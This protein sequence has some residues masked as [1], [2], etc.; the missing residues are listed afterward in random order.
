MPKQ[1]ADL[2]SRVSASKP[3]PKDDAYH[4][5]WVENLIQHALEKLVD[6]DR[7]YRTVQMFYF[8]AKTQREIAEA[9]DRKE[10]DVENDLAAA[11]RRLRKWIAQQI[12]EYCS[13][14]EEYESEVQDLQKFL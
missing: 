10:K 11:R 8:Q 14:R 9:L 4:R 7:Q 3:D 1:D 6:D 2:Y 13:S 12:A 5:L